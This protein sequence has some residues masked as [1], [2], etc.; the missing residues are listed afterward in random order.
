MHTRRQISVKV[1]VIKYNKV[2]EESVFKWIIKREDA[3]RTRRIVEE[4]IKVT[5]P[6]P[7]LVECVQKLHPQYS[8]YTTHML[9][10]VRGLQNQAQTD[11]SVAKC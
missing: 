9:W 1:D 2:Q 7:K 8:S 5:H 4:E 11:F 6:H 10:V 3:I